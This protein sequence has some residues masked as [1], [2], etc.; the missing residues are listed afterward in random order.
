MWTKHALE[1][2]PATVFMSA[3]SGAGKE[4]ALQSFWNSLAVHGMIL[5]SNGIRGTENIDK[6][7]PQGNSVL[8]ITSM[9]SL[10]DVERPTKSERYLAA[11]QGQNFASVANALKGRLKKAPVETKTSAETKDISTV[12]KEKNIVLPTAPNPVGNYTP[13]PDREIWFSLIRWH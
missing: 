1:G 11:L 6:N 4:L 12:L 5:V 10:K 2:M 13:L 3:G 8:G 7:I 9:A